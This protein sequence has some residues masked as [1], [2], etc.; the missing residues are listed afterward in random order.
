MS[1]V[2]ANINPELKKEA[3]DCLKKLGLTSSQAIRMFY[4]QI[5]LKKGLPFEVSIPHTPNKKTV[6]AI[7][8]AR[9]GIDLHE[10]DNIE[11]L[12]KELDV[13]C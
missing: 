11:Q 8:N 12:K 9:K 13:N 10:V 7:E 6:E 2:K 1:T 5:A 4:S 3:E